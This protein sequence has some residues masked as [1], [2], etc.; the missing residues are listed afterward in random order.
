MFL[1]IF[2]SRNRLSCEAKMELTVELRALFGAA[3]LERGAE[4]CYERSSGFPKIHF[5]TRED[6]GASDNHVGQYVRLTFKEVAVSTHA[7]IWGLGNTL[8]TFQS[9]CCNACNACAVFP[10]A[11]RTTNWRIVSLSNLI[12]PKQFFT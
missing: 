8:L 7:A 5:F 12:G 9:T 2:E 6:V 11:S 3:V 1:S 4:W 10:D